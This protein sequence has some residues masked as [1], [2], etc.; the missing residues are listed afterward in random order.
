MRL[1]KPNLFDAHFHIIDHQF[2]LQPNQGYLPP[3]FTVSD[4]LTRTRAL[5]IKGGAIVSGSF[6][7]FDQSYLLA[8]LQLLGPAFVGV[9]Q[10]PASVTDE[11]IIE[12]NHAG[13]RAIRFNLKRG[14]DNNSVD[15]LKTLAHRVYELAKWHVEFYVDSTD[16]PKLTPF[17][18]TLPVVCIDHLGLSKQGFPDLLHLVERG[19]KVKACGFGRVDFDITKALKQ[20]AEINPNALMFGTD[21]PS[22]RAPRPFLDE[23]IQLIQTSLGDSLT[24]RALFDNAFEFYGFKRRRA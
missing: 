3:E 9:T 19:V 1:T 23:D 14:D 8:A 16:L 2:P 11:K 18:L 6:Q 5:S 22:T 12:L 17:I 7:A 13:V 15:Q 20:I 10:L 4:Y 24:Q 21:L